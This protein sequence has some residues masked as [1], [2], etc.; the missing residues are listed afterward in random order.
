MLCGI[1]YLN[2]LTY[3]YLF[4]DCSHSTLSFTM[5]CLEGQEKHSDVTSSEKKQLNEASFYR[6][7]IFI[8]QVQKNALTEKKI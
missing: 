4:Y 8:F 6:Y 2:I 5:T 3:V 1:S 7:S